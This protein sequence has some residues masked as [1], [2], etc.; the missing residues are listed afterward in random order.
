M[1][2]S[3]EWLALRAPADDAARDKGL[4]V[5]LLDWAG[6]R[7]L[8]IADIGGGSGAA[9][10]VLGGRLP[11][12][13]WRVYDNDAAL[14]SLIPES[15][16]VETATLDLNA[17]IDAVFDAKPDLI[18]A[19]AFLDL[20]SEVWLAR[21]VQRL[22]ESG[23]ALYA[24]LTYDGRE[25]WRPEPPHEAEA[26]AALHADM[27]KDKG[28]GPALGP[29]APDTLRN[30]LTK[31]PFHLH[32]AQSDWRV[33]PGRLLAELANG[34]AEAIRP[35]MAQH[36]YEEWKSARLKATSALIGHRDALALSR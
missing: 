12:A 31:A 23:A 24:P 7:P 28:F 33:A 4:E 9:L 32:E 29:K 36:K 27:S 18:T 3:A 8:R 34:S 35:R 13:S 1:S 14:L 15:P 20:V 21:F 26:L 5:R 10:R 11:N 6:T 16:T 19:F 30:L 22:S 2:F 25:V 17:D